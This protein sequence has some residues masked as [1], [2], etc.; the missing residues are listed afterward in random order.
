MYFK[1]K[2][3]EFL[4]NWKRM[5]MRKPLIIKGARQIG[6][7]ESI[8][9]FANGNYENIIYINFALDKKYSAI[10]NDGYDVETVIKNVTLVN[11]NLKFIPDKTIIIFDEIQEYPDIATTLKAFN[12]DGKYDVICSGSMLGINYKKIH[13]NSVGYKTDYEMFSMDF[14]EFLW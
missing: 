3:D 2:I 8:L 1:R 10:V 11:P 12:I 4:F 14:E 7:T 13:S 5:K 9:H 6:K